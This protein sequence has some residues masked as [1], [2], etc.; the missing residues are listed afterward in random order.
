MLFLSSQQK[1]IMCA[2]HLVTQ[3]TKKD[4]L[5]VSDL[6]DSIMYHFNKNTLKWNGLF[7]S[8][9]GEKWTDFQCSRVPLPWL[10][11]THLQFYPP[12][13]LYHQYKRQYSGKGTC[14]SII[15]KIVFRS[16]KPPG[17]HRPNLEKCC[18]MFYS[19]FHQKTWNLGRTLRWKWL[20]TSHHWKW[21][22]SLPKQRKMPT[23]PRSRGNKQRRH[24]EA[25]WC[26]AWLELYLSDE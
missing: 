26:K 16:Q 24:T 17:F 10:M 12:L 2:F 5:E 19:L 1:Y 23:A 13:L 4:V 9:A 7:T 20:Q 21:V 25:L 3:D 11:W 6:I 22:T 15:M 18:S 8:C 14:V